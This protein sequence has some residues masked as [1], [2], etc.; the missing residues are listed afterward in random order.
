MPT[1][2]HR[3]KKG[4][5]CTICG[6]SRHGYGGGRTGSTE[7]RDSG[8]N[9]LGFVAPV[10]DESR[11][12][13]EANAFVARTA[14]LPRCRH[15]AAMRDHGGNRLYPDCGC[16]GHMPGRRYGT[17]MGTQCASVALVCGSASADARSRVRA[18][19]ALAAARCA[20]GAAAA[21]RMRGATTASP[22][23]RRVRRRA[24]EGGEHVREVNAVQS[25]R[26]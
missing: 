12:L 6:I 19:G 24:G 26:R 23:S 5:V 9:S 7:Y 21:H 2:R 17:P 20:R 22:A 14:P 25:E 10:C 18:T 4:D 16:N 15:G 13:R 3:W 8:G 1:N 11:P